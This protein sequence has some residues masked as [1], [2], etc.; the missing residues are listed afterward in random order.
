MTERIR[1]IR[2]HHLEAALRRRFGWSLGWTDRRHATLVEVETTGGLKGWGDGSAGPNPAVALGQSPFDARGIWEAQRPP[3]FRQARRGESI[4]G[5]LDTALYDLQGQI[6]GLPVHRLLGHQHRDRVQPY[7]T[8]LYRQDWPDVAAGL[9]E[10]AAGWVAQGYRVLKMKIGYGPDL[11]VRLVKAV[12]AAI[13]DE[14]ALGVDANCAYDA[15]T[16]IGLARRLEAFHPAWWEEPLLADDLEGYRR[17][18]ESTAIP[19]ASGESLGADALIRD[20]IAPRAVAIVQPEIELIGLTGALQVSHA[21]W[22]QGLRVIPHNWGTAVRTTAILHWMAT[23]PPVTEALAS[24]QVLFEFD[25]TESPFRDA[26]VNEPVR[27][28]A[29]GLLPVPEGPGLGIGVNEE[30]VAG[31]RVRLEEFAA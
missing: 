17:L 26:V 2:V 8:A 18:R 6:L 24:A 22:T 12:R 31:Y 23:M 25:Q 7:L 29:D 30:A 10:E 20:Y 9:A 21:A 4:A 27:P 1:R 28:G 16:A 11:D 15:G 13:G 5:G 3:M 19:L 14:I